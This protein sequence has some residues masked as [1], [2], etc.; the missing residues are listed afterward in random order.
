MNFA[1][2]LKSNM[3]TSISVVNKQV[4]LTI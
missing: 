2:T 1:S 3:N 4:V